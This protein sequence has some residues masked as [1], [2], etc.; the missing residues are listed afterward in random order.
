LSRRSEAVDLPPA[1][2]RLRKNATSAERRLW[3]TLRRRG[4]EGF[5]FRR[6]V[7]LVGFIVDFA[8]FE[9]R[10][11]VE[12][13]GAT[14]STDW[15][16]AYDKRREAKLVEAGNRVIRFANGDVFDNLEGVLEAIRSMLLELKPEGAAPSKR[17]D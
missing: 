12:I 11:L 7:E 2:R 10:L 3:F 14:H 9:A 6:Q 17:K 16:I 15:E 8:C 5:R 13:D 1:A 4:L